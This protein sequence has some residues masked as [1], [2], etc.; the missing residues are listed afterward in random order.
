MLD[1]I[2]YF[3]PRLG[4]RG[5]KWAPNLKIELLKVNGLILA[6]KTQAS[7]FISDPREYDLQLNLE[8]E[9]KYVLLGSKG[10]KKQ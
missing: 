5:L 9:R 7:L 10:L 3:G 4:I 8:L 1:Q 6:D 2:F